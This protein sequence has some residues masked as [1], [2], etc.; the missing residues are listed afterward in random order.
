M[1][2][3]G[4]GNGDP[5]KSWLKGL[6]RALAHL[7]Q[8][9]IAEDSVC[10]PIYASLLKTSG[11]NTAAQSKSAPTRTYKAKDDRDARRKFQIRQARVA[12]LIKEDADPRVSVNPGSIATKIDAAKAAGVAGNAL[13]QV[14]YYLKDKQNRNAVLGHIIDQ[15]PRDGEIILIG[16]SLGS[17]IAIDLL[18]QLPEKVHVRRFL[19][20]GSPAGA[21]S[22]HKHKKDI[23]PDIPYQRVDD[24]TNLIYRRDPVST[25]RGLGAAFGGAQDFWI[26]WPFKLS[27]DRVHGAEQY[28]AHPA[29]GRLIA[30]ILYPSQAVVP[31]SSNLVVRISDDEAGVLLSIAYGARIS[32]Y[33]QRTDKDANKIDSRAGRFDDALGQLQASL[34]AQIKERQ[35]AGHPIPEEFVSIATGIRPQL[36]RRWSLSEAISMTTLLALTNIV[37]PYE[38]E[39]DEAPLKVLPDVFTDLGLPGK[40]GGIVA[41]AIEEV[42]GAISSG[43]TWLTPKARVAAVAAGIAL[44]AG[45]PIGL[46]MVG[47]SGVAGAAAITSS[48]A[49]FGPGGMM[50]GLAMLGGLASTGSMVTTA[51]AT[52]RN[53]PQSALDP[54]SIAIRAA[55]AYAHKL[56]NEPYDDQ[57]W[58]DLADAET[59]VAAKINMLEVFSDP[60]SPELEQQRHVQS[61]IA[62]LIRFM[63]DNDLEPETVA[64]A[65]GIAETEKV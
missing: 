7:G 5:G 18:D 9:P 54:T 23:L 50:G 60:K 15:M 14:S 21:P 29:A 62:K 10:S 43:N 6:N 48:L 46:A 22:L 28:L 49:A 19:T 61:L 13:S 17:V 39:L 52:I 36:P 57:L 34:V 32:T 51:A 59:A 35:A 42:T 20:I 31:S 40:S 47:A 1:Y 56:L 38:I 63:C 37:A 45:G 24:W 41:K 53:K 30:D 12:R 26:S 65:L 33:L 44:L 11:A 55:I 25:G 4:V 58:Y 64:T 27:I 3:H 16:H 8:Q 2:L